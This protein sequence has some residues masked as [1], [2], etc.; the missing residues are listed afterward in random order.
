MFGQQA[1]PRAGEFERFDVGNDRFIDRRLPVVGGPCDGKRDRGDRRGQHREFKRVIPVGK[2]RRAF[3]NHADVH[4]V[5]LK[6]LSGVGQ[7]ELATVVG[8]AKGLEH[9]DDVAV[10]VH[11]GHFKGAGLGHAQVR[12]FAGGGHGVETNR[13][14]VLPFQ[15]R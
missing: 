12:R 13:L 1:V 11:E 6:R 7:E 2:E 4:V 9:V 10:L 8:V 14:F 15:R 3:L 5:K